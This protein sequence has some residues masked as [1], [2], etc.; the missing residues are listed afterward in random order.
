MLLSI[1][2]H[3]EE[4]CTSIVAG[5]NW[6]I[7]VDSFYFSMNT[8]SLSLFAGTSRTFLNSVSNEIIDELFVCGFSKNNNKKNGQ[9][10]KCALL[11]IQ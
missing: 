9:M 5:G 3:F 10:I 2:G 6:G 11:G 8:F 7:K 1:K 4:E